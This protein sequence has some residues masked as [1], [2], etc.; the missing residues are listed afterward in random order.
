VEDASTAALLTVDAEPEPATAP[1][2]E[3]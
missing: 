1:M 3:T 2:E